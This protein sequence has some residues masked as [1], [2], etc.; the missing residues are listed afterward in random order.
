MQAENSV[1]NRQIYWK[2]NRPLKFE[3]NKTAG[4]ENIPADLNFA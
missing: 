3:N 4:P 1:V 2:S